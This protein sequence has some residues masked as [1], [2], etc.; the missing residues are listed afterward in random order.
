MVE[1]IIEF[2]NG[3]ET[4]DS[5]IDAC[6]NSNE[7]SYHHKVP[8][9]LDDL[10]WNDVTKL[11]HSMDLESRMSLNARHLAQQHK[12]KILSM[13]HKL[14]KKKKLTM[15]ASYKGYSF[16]TYPTKE[17]QRKSSNYINE[18]GI[19]N[20]INEVDSTDPKVSQVCLG[21]ILKQVDSTL[22]DLL[23]S[24]LIIDAQYLLMYPERSIVRLNYLHFVPDTHKVCFLSFFLIQKQNFFTGR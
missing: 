9:V 12:R 17:F 15:R 8:S 10:D 22:N 21:N 1:Q 19:Y 13:Q 7:L 5:C 11:I 6:D 18:T 2:N 20:F 16:H 23:H 14:T 3:L 4:Q 24:E